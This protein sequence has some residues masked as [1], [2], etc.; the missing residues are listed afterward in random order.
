MPFENFTS[1]SYWLKEILDKVS[2]VYKPFPCYVV[3]MA[4]HNLIL[5]RNED[6]FVVCILLK[7]HLMYKNFIAN[8]YQVTLYYKKFILYLGR[9]QWSVFKTVFQD[10]IELEKYVEKFNFKIRKKSL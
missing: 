8:M 2:V 4:G 6:V 10:I 9:T 7:V 3:Y 1:Y 5:Y